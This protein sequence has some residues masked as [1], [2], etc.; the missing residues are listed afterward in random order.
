MHNESERDPSHKNKEPEWKMCEDVYKSNLVIHT[1]SAIFQNVQLC[2]ET[3]ERMYDHHT[4]PLDVRSEQITSV[5]NQFV[6]VTNMKHEDGRGKHSKVQTPKL[7]GNQN[8][9]NLNLRGKLLSNHDETS[10]AVSIDFANLCPDSTHSQVNSNAEILR[11]DNLCST[12]HHSHS[13]LIEPCNTLSAKKFH[14]VQLITCAEF[15][16]RIS[17]ANYLSYTMLDKHVEIDQMFDNVSMMTSF[18]SLNNVHS[19]KFTFNLIIE[20]VFDK[21]FVCSICITCDNLSEFKTNMSNAKHC[22]PYFS[23]L[24]VTKLFSVC[25]FEKQILFPCSYSSS[26][27]INNMQSNGIF[28]LKSLCPHQRQMSLQGMFLIF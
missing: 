11:D 24:E 23:G 12:L 9:T 1:S 15:F 8:S 2:N 26:K 27:D 6:V 28:G 4:T 10:T 19:C 16:K 17:S 21:F 25:C 18:R 20:Q 5:Q 3:E 22:E 7:Q 14:H 13:I